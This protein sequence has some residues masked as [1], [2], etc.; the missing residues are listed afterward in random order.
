MD[1]LT[2]V[3]CDPLR[4]TGKIWRKSPPRTTS[5]PPNGI[6]LLEKWFIRTP[7]YQYWYRLVTV[8]GT[9]NGWLTSQYQ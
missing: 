4:M 3:E 5:L 1:A 9:N 7:G 6:T 2:I 8:A